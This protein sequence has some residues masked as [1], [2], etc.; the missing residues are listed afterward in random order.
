MD[1]FDKPKGGTELMYNELIKRL[2]KS[3][4]EE[5][6]IFNYYYQ[7]D[8]TKTTIFWNQLSYDQDAV[9]FLRTPSYRD[10][11]D[12][13]V[14]VSHWQAERF[15]HIFNIPAYKIRVIKNANIEIFKKRFK[16]SNKIRLCYTSTPWRGLDVL[17]KAWEILQLQDCELHVFSSCKIYGKDFGKNDSQ[18]EHLYKKCQELPGVVYRGSISNEELRKE[19]PTF[20]ILAYP[21]TFE[22]TSCIAVIEALS[23][24]LRVITSNLGALPETT[25]GWA[26]LYQY[27]P[28]SELHAYRFA[29]ILK[30]EIELFKNNHFKTHLQDQIRVYSQKWSWDYRI[31]D[32][33]KFLQSISY[34]FTTKNVFDREVFNEVYKQNAYGLTNFNAEDVVIDLGAHIGSF[35]RLCYD[36]GCRNIHSY[37]ADL[38][39]YNI[40][41]ENLTPL[42]VNLYHKAVW[43]SNEPSQSLKISHSTIDS[44]ESM[45]TISENGTQFV[46]SIGLDSILSNFNRIK[47][48]KIDIEGS[49]YPVLYTSTQLYKVKEIVGE[50]HE[51]L[52]T[53]NISINGYKQNI[54]DL[55][56]FLTDQGFKIIHLKESFSLVKNYKFGQFKAINLKLI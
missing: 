8:F 19:L 11:I 38:R 36:K 55:Y 18:F 7:A 54:E 25:E 5:F 6:S 33:V 14:F 4:L 41:Y 24:G 32:W 15:R 40:A 30:E 16:K 17:L 27:L 3:F 20:D 35:S 37:E 34:N 51:F 50:Y 29:N 23:A 28:N 1:L 31:N 10:K 52:N 13:F 39:N 44:R 12:Y 53:K 46:E 42:S 21:N 43:K 9:Q 49:E 56:K 26:R 2:P 22:E 45:M 48:L 47:L